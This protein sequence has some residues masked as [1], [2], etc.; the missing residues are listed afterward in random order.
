MLSLCLCFQV[1]AS[2]LIYSR[3]QKYQKNYKQ[4]VIKRKRGLIMQP[5]IAGASCP[6]NN[7][8][9]TCTVHTVQCKCI[10]T[11]GKNTFYTL[12]IYILLFGLL[13]GA[14]CPGNN[15]TSLCT[16]HTVQ[17]KCIFTI[18]K[19]IFY[20][21]D[22]YIRLVRLVV[23]ASCPG[24]SCTILCTGHTVHCKCISTIGKYILHFGQIHS[25]IWTYSVGQLSWKQLHKLTAMQCQDLH[26]Q[27]HR[28]LLRSYLRSSASQRCNVAPFPH[29]NIL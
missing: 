18:M 23:G 12:D 7:R 2:I 17:C 29:C 8:T 27:Q 25:T 5:Y 21:L 4:L 14:S 11:I 9:S 3:L 6:G 16:V 1:V 15:C 26:L 24:Y 22:K 10:F 13:V 20:M 28:C 19:N